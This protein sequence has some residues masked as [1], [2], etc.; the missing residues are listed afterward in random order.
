M[1]STRQTNPHQRRL[2][3]RL[4]Q[5]HS[6]DVSVVFLRLPAK[7]ATDGELVLEFRP[8]RSKKP[9]R[10][11]LADIWRA[12]V[13]NVELSHALDGVEQAVGRVREARQF[14]FAEPGQAEVLPFPL[15]A[16]KR[17]EHA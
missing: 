12:K 4:T 13:G 6:R 14:H 7:E 11:R 3:C 15:P 17:L 16:S 5:V 2:L 9:V 8:P 1:R 10:V